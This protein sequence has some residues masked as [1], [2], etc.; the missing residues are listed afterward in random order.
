MPDEDGDYH[1]YDILRLTHISATDTFIGHDG[2][3]LVIAPSCFISQTG[4]EKHLKLMVMR[5]N[6]K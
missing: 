1:S 2:M 5:K 6:G 4:K 3:R